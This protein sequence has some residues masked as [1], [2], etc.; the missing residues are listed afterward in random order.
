ME[1]GGWD[2]VEDGETWEVAVSEVDEEDEGDPGVPLDGERLEENLDR[3]GSRKCWEEMPGD[4]L[5]E[6]DAR[7]QDEATADNEE[8]L[9]L[10]EEVRKYHK[11]FFLSL[12]RCSNPEPKLISRK[13][14]G[15][16]WWCPT[17]TSRT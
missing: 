10:R 4:D 15:G 9:A 2:E 13:S 8:G 7:D 17:C 11:P 3:S 1:V 12:V 14:R 5:G 6:E 16:R